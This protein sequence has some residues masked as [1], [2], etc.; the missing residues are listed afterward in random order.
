[1][2]S[3][4]YNENNKYILQFSYIPCSEELCVVFVQLY[5][6]D[7]ESRKNSKYIILLP[8][9]KY[10]SQIEYSIPTV[11]QPAMYFEAFKRASAFAVSISSAMIYCF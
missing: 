2:L 3:Q 11:K 8:Q 6:T 10:F 7:Q 9:K 5:P 1:M 4:Y